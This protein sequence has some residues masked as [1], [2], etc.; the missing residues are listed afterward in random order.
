MEG[1][2]RHFHHTFSVISSVLLGDVFSPSCS[3]QLHNGVILKVDLELE[4]YSPSLVL[5]TSDTMNDAEP[6]A[7]PSIYLLLD[8]YE[9]PLSSREDHKN[10]LSDIISALMSGPLLSNIRS[11]SIWNDGTDSCLEKLSVLLPLHLT[12]KLTYTDGD[13]AHL[14]YMCHANTSRYLVR[15]SMTCSDSAYARLSERCYKSCTC[16][17]YRILGRTWTFPGLR[18]HI[19][20]C[21]YSNGT[22]SIPVHLI[23]CASSV[24][25]TS[26]GW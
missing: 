11:L 9:V 17:R 23:L 12:E 24:R 26:H 10:R 14:L 1:D 8:C 20:T 2:L 6:L 22:E 16:A 7:V 21:G 19:A 4:K 18:P 25:R 5:P 13:H 15:A 3:I